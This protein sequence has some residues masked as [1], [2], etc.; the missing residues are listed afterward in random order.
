M[1][2]SGC[3]ATVEIGADDAGVL[4]QG[5]EKPRA[6]DKTVRLT[7]KAHDVV[8]KRAREAGTD[9]KTY[10]SGWI[11][12]VSASPEVPADL[13]RLLAKGY[14]FAELY[15]AQL[16]SELE[17]GTLKVSVRDL[18]RL[19]NLV[20]KLNSIREKSGSGAPANPAVLNEVCYP[21]ELLKAY[22]KQQESSAAGDY[23]ET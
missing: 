15:L 3:A 7:A 10:L 20:V 2:D 17:A 9:R 5:V 8:T 4:T 13:S 14:D 11:L 19:V 22:H 12:G 23:E 18:E 6:P 1:P 21:R 16:I